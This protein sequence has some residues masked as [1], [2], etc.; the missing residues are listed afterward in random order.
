MKIIKI[1]SVQLCVEF[2]YGNFFM[3]IFLWEFFLRMFWK[4]FW[5]LFQEGDFGWWGVG[6]EVLPAVQDFF[7]A[8]VWNIPPALLCVMLLHNSI[9]HLHIF[10][11][12]K[13]NSIIHLFF[14]CFSS[15]PCFIPHVH[16]FWWRKQP[17]I[18]RRECVKCFFYFAYSANF[19]AFILFLLFFFFFSFSLST[20][21]SFTFIFIIFYNLFNIIYYLLF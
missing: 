9:I 7:G 8:I 10:F 2:F 6:M 19:A 4:I 3:G 1:I 13:N 12:L 14:Y 16:C 17:I 15:Y 21:L 20:F 18:T 11:Y 5:E